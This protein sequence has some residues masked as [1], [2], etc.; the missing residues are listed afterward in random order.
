MLVIYI[1]VY[2]Y[3]ISVKKTI[4]KTVHPKNFYAHCLAT[5]YD[6]SLFKNEEKI[7][8]CLV[9]MGETFLSRAFICVSFILL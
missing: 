5:I 8:F 3:T 2:K 7:R 6:K 1:R 9:C 4:Y